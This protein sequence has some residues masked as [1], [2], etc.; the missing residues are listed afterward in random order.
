MMRFFA[1]YDVKSENYRFPFFQQTTGLAMRTFSEGVNDP[2]SELHKY[3]DDFKLYQ[4]GTWD[5]TTGEMTPCEH[6]CA[7][8]RDV[9]KP[10]PRP[11]L[12]PQEKTLEN[13]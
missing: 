6:M 9:L 4:L 10:D 11:D 1:I 3:P 12:F 8:A 2:R 7:Y 13:E 5:E